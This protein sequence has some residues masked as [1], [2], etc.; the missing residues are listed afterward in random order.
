M[1]GLSK[2]SHTRLSSLIAVA[3]LS[4][5]CSALA[6]QVV[7]SGL[8]SGERYDSFIVKYRT[9]SPQRSDV[10]KLK[11]S[12]A[13][14]GKNAIGAASPALS[15]SRRLAI[16][17][18]VLK[19]S[20]KLDRVQAET[21]MRQLAS[22]PDVE[23]VQVNARA[24][25]TLIPNDTDFGRQWGF[26]GANGIRAQR[27]WDRATGQGA[28]VAVLDTGITN[29]PDLNGN[30]LP[31]YDFVSDA[32]AARDGNGRDADPADQGNW[33]DDANFCRISNSDWH[34]THVAGTVAATTNN[35]AGVA[36][37]AFN[38]RV[39]P[40]RV[41]ARCGGTTADIA[42]AI[43]WASGGDVPGVPANQNPAD[44]INMSLRGF[45]ACSRAYQDAINS[46]VGRGT[47]VVVAAG[48]DS[49]DVASIQ[50]ASCANV[51][52]VGATGEAGTAAGF[53]NFGA[54]VDIAAPGVDIYST[55]NN[56]VTLPGAASYAS[57]N[58]TS[59]AAPHV[60]GVVAL[61]QSVA[62]NNPR[63]P[64]QIEALI[65][66]NATPFA[67]APNNRIGSGIVNAEAVV[68]AV[69][70][71]PQQ[72]WYLYRNTL[73]SVDGAG[74]ATCI[75]TQGRP[76]DCYQLPRTDREYLLQV[77]ASATAAG[78]TVVCG[79][80]TY[81][82]AWGPVPTDLNHWCNA[83]PRERPALQPL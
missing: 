29:H 67:V 80:P 42:D 79:S 44:V 68:N 81:V 26:S 2:F 60:A 20:N 18:D 32:A 36:G 70:P 24:Y 23:Y 47:T 57:Y 71:Q 37:T 16:G 21:L 35:A 4:A 30:V 5:P 83:F 82:A 59:M 74:Q 3:L 76:A 69:A 40:I 78:R 28:V 77:V 53:S 65:T 56:G 62:G 48:N 58:G 25:P 9:G 13:Q 49:V 22:N 55:L 51:I 15:H 63:T 73:V 38:A 75:T 7:T 11:S 52:T 46:A 54:G 1:L 43:I 33:N 50:P 8:E 27:A 64:A 17:A 72:Q 6:G 34:G 31:G 14:A 19:A 61:A 41:L 39:V 66:G 45:G 10:G 12:L